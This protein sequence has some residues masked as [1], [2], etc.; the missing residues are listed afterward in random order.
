[1]CHLPAKQSRAFTVSRR[2]QALVL[3]VQWKRKLDWLEDVNGTIKNHPSLEDKKTISWP[4]YHSTTDQQR[5]RAGLSAL[6]ALLPLFP[7]QA[8]SVA[9]IRHAMDVIKACVNYLNPG[10]VPVAL[11]FFTQ[12]H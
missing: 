12:S 5:N 6:S 7:D 9:M 8:K 1:M 10:Q 3:I 4:A 11:V 2:F